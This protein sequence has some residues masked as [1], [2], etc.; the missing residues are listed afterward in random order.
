MISADWRLL[1]ACVKSSL[2]ERLEQQTPPLAKADLPH[3]QVLRSRPRP[4]V[5]GVWGKS[6]LN[7]AIRQ[8]D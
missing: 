6:R 7:N 1:F 8:S 5:E 2:A 4:H 3:D